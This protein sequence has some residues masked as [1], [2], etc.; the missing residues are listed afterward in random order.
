MSEVV[1]TGPSLGPPDH[2]PNLSD[3]FM[4]GR[5]DGVVDQPVAAT[6]DEEAPRAGTWA[7][8]VPLEAVEAERLEGGGVAQYFSPPTELR[9]ADHDQPLGPVDVV[10]VEAHRFTDP[11]TGHRQQPEECLESCRPQRWC[12]LAGG[13]HQRGDIGVGVQVWSSGPV[14]AG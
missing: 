13:T 6:G 8:L 1:D 4:K 9:A 7:E 10:V 14:T 12:E 5:V 2:Q 3:Q 11:H